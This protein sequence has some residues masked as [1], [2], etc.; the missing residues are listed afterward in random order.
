MEELAKLEAER[1]NLGY[2]P[3]SG[4]AKGRIADASEEMIQR[5]ARACRQQ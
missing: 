4:N 1:G 3:E 5:K 2:L